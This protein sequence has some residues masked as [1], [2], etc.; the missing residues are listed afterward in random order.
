[1]N[2]PLPPAPEMSSAFTEQA[3][4]SPLYAA[5]GAALAAPPDADIWKEIVPHL[6]WRGI[7]SIDNEALAQRLSAET[8]ELEAKL[9][10]RLDG[11]AP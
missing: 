3:G 4:N 8:K 2:M 5:G 6:A 1:M 9:A 11:H 7:I 10:H